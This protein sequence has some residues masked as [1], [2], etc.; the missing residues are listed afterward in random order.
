[1]NRLTTLALLLLLSPACSTEPDPPPENQ[2]R[3]TWA[4]DIAPLYR[5][6][7]VSCHSSGGIAP[8]SLEDYESAKLMAVASLAAVRDRVMPPWLI[9]DDGS[10]QSFSDSRWLLPRAADRRPRRHRD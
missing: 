3:A 8:F 7:C 6:R 2:P 9:T 4:K 10:C 5:E 1:M